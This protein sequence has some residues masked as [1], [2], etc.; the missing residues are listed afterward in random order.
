MEPPMPE[1]E[2]SREIAINLSPTLP[3]LPPTAANVCI[4]N[5]TGQ[6]FILDFGFADPLVIATTPPREGLIIS[7]V[8]VGR[9]VI[10]QDLAVK[11]RDQLIRILGGP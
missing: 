5:N 11:L 4:V 6:T 9:I 3:A 7:A 10:A 8:H 2:E 1:A